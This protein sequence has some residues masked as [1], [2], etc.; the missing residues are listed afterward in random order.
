MGP[1]L[2]PEDESETKEWD[3]LTL[4]TRL[5]RT[6]TPKTCF[7]AH[8]DALAR[9]LEVYNSRL[10]EQ[11]VILCRAGITQFSSVLNS[12]RKNIEKLQ[13]ELDS[14]FL[15]F[16]NLRLALY[17]SLQTISDTVADLN[18]N[19]KTPSE[20]RLQLDREDARV[21]LLIRLLYSGVRNCSWQT[22]TIDILRVS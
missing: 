18:L 1:Q 14:S 7:R 3:K 16:Y 20:K 6:D 5:F 12:Q 11:E 10:P 15:R 4:K 19:G 2:G 21:C 8:I 17:R 9:H 13:N 22:P